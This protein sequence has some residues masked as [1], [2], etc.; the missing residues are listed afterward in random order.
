M[1]ARCCCCCRIRTLFSQAKTTPLHTRNTLKKVVGVTR[2]G[3]ASGGKGSPN[4][5][6]RPHLAPGPSGC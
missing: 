3:T 5:C 2:S 6:A 1:L 4:N